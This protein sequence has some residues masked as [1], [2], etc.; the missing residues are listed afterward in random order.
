[1]KQGGGEALRART[2]RLVAPVTC[3][4][5]PV[6]GHQSRPWSCSA[7]HSPKL[8]YCDNITDAAVIGLASSCG[9]LTS[10]NLS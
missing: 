7:L 9:G 8:R 6:R 1:M 3:P 5:P 10:V 4:P 2:M